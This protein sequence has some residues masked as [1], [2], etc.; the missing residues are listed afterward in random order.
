[1][2]SIVQSTIRANVF[3]TVYDLLTAQLSAGTVTAA[4]IDDSPT[5]PQVV[6]NP[7]SIKILKNTFNNT[8]RS[9]N[10]ELEI[11]L[12][13]KKNKQIDQIADEISTDIFSNE[14]SLASD[15]IFI[16]DVSDSDEDTFFWNDQKI[17]TKSITIEFKANV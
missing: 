12:F 4:F 3:E 13:C 2:V 9:Y 17:H 8:N 14:S 16:D 1:M 10:G 7:S 11:E 6:I 15:G 5:F